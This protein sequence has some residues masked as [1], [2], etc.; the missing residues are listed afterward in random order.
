MYLA[1]LSLPLLGAFLAPNRKCGL[2]A[3][4]LLSVICMGFT[5]FLATLAFFEV[6]LS[7]SPV[8]LIFASWLDSLY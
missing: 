4:P 7:G 2:L 8:S 1:L 6:A 3:G 5:A